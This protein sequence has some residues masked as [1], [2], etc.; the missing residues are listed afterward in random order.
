MH[1][2]AA[3][4]LNH[5]EVVRNGLTVLRD[6]DL[7][8]PPAAITAIVGSSGAGKTTLLSVLNGGLAISRGV[9][10]VPELG[11]LTVPAVLRK[12]RR[13]TANIYQEY[14]LIG[15]LTA[16]DNVLLGLADQRN[17]MM[18]ILRWPERDQVAAAEALTE[19]G[20]IDKAL[21]RVADLSG[22]ERQRVAIARALVRRPKLMIADE[23]FASVD[24]ALA[25]RFAG[26]LRKA[27]EAHG[28]TII[29]ALH[30]VQLALKMADYVVGLSA[31]KVVLNE[32]AAALVPADL[33][34]L[35]QLSDGNRQEL[36]TAE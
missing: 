8:F 1:A 11:P 32:P 25:G 17:S 27:V 7:E 31:G 36:G 5:V 16:L 30:Q 21:R 10:T 24:P 33:N 28:L 18:S 3:I 12:H 34:R 19:V 20:L 26:L 23:P 9:V 22:G 13:Q 2:Q 4:I 35:F 15:R 14:A 29:V 6:V